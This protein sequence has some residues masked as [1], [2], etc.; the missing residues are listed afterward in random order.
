MIPLWVFIGVLAL[1]FLVCGVA[2]RQASAYEDLHEKLDIALAERNKAE[3]ALV[4]ANHDLEKANNE[5][6]NLKRANSR[7]EA[8]YEKRLK[9]AEDENRQTTAKYHAAKEQL[10]RLSAR[11]ADSVSAETLAQVQQAKQALEAD[12]KQLQQWQEEAL[13]RIRTLYTAR[14]HARCHR[15]VE[16]YELL[17]EEIN[18]A[19]LFKLPPLPEWVANCVEYWVGETTRA[20]RSCHDSEAEAHSRIVEKLLAKE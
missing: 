3:D 1:F 11:T 13:K 8:A 6:E 5:N 2:V 14:G 20:V 15:A 12:K 16:L 9:A 4:N 7:M 17:G 10:V 18:E 19:E